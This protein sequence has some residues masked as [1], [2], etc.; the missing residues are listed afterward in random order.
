MAAVAARTS[1]LVIPTERDARLASE[2][3][4]KLAR[5]LAEHPADT[6][7]LRVDCAPHEEIQVPAEA[8]RLF[9]AILAE[10]AQGNAVTLIPVHA[11]LTTQEAADLLN[12]SRP[13]LVRL[14]EEGQ[15]PF[16]KVGTHRRIKMSELLAYKQRLEASQEQ[17]FAKLAELSQALDLGY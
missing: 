2:A 11:E 1:D 6:G 5:V 14:L 9:S 12:V 7:V 3:R 15:I 16:H 17:A 4:R 10:L 8:L 13:Y